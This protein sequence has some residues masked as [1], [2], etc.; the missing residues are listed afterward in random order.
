MNSLNA[1]NKLLNG[2]EEI[3]LSITEI[4]K[5]KYDNWDEMTDQQKSDK[6]NETYAQLGIYYESGVIGIKSRKQKNGRYI[7]FVSVAEEFRETKG[8]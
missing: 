7:D 1:L 8:E 4:C 3:K 6:H 2:K 5:V